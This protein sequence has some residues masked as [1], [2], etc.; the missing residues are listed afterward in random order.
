LIAYGPTARGALFGIDVTFQ[1]NFETFYQCMP[2][3][4]LLYNAGFVDTKRTQSFDFFEVM[5]TVT[6]PRDIGNFDVFAELLPDGSG[7]VV[8]EPLVAPFFVHNVKE[9]NT[10]DPFAVSRLKDYNSK[11]NLYKSIPKKVRLT[12]IKFPFGTVGTTDFIGGK[13]NS[14]RKQVELHA[15]NTIFDCEANMAAF[16]KV[17]KFPNYFITWK[18]GVKGTVENLSLSPQNQ[19]GASQICADFGSLSM[20]QNSKDRME[21]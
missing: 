14:S 3:Y 17:K 18:I 21:Y 4:H 16:G 1:L 13:R 20:M 5:K 8:S 9:W 19:D 2:G 12:T 7:M 15:F 11:M 6:D 10:K